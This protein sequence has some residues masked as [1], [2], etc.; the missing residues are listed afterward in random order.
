[1]GSGSDGDPF[2]DRFRD[3]EKSADRLSDNV[4]DDSRD[5]NTGYSDRD[6][7]AHLLR[8]AHADGCGD[9]FWKKGDILFMRQPEEK[10]QDQNRCHGGQNTGHSP[11]QNRPGVLFEQA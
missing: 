8:Y 3:V 5:D 2:G 9:G 4:A 11:C 1:M 6:D 10:R 7:T